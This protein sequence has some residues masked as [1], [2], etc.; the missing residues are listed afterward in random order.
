MSI[1]F[2]K[3]VF[4]ICPYCKCKVFLGIDG[5]KDRVYSYGEWYHKE[6]AIKSGINLSVWTDNGRCE[7]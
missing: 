3:P 6:C 7:A 5:T 2:T 1:E 4:R